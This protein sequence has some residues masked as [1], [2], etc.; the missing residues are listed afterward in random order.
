MSRRQARLNTEAADAQQ[1]QSQHPQVSISMESRDAAET[2]IG[3]GLGIYV[4]MC[5]FI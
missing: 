2:S 1:A 3:E 5:V 4:C